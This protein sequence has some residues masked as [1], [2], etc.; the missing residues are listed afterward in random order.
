MKKQWKMLLLLL[1][2]FFSGSEQ[3]RA[4]EGDIV[5]LPVVMYHHISRKPESWNN[6]V[7]SVDEFERDMRYLAE[8]GWKSVSMRQ[9]LDWYQGKFEMPEKAFMITFDDGFESTKAY[10]APILEAYGFNAVVAVIGSVCEKFSICDEHHAELSN[11]S[12]EDAVELAQS[13]TFE[14]QCHTWDMHAYSPRFGCNKL[15]RESVAT[16][17]RNLSTD[18]SRFLTACAGRGLDILPSIAY[19]YGAYDSDTT[20]VVRDMGFL[21]AFT[22]DERVNELRGE[23]EELFHLARYNRPH[24]PGSEKFFSKWEKSD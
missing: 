9:L 4:E 1:C 14:F 11:L 6:Y 3:V 24:G 18:L 12:W 2:M 5:R 15:P 19:P 10:A 7:V 8:N 23:E 13:G 20:D 22:C 16:Y 21:A 17:R